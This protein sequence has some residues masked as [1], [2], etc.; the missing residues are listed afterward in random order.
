MLK[1]VVVVALLAVAGYFYAGP[2]AVSQLSAT[3]LGALNGG[4]GVGR[5]LANG[6]KIFTKDELKQ[7][8]GNDKTKGTYVAVA[9]NVFDVSEGK[10]YQPGGGYAFF[11]GV[12]GSRAYVTGDFK[13]D[14]TDD[15]DGLSI[16]DFRGIKGWLKFYQDHAKYK[17]VGKVIGLFYNENG[18]L[19]DDR[20]V[21]VPEK[22]PHDIYP[23]C[24][25]KYNHQIDGREIWCT[26]K[27]GGIDRTWIGVPRQISMAEKDRDGKSQEKCVCVPEGTPTAY[28]ITEY[29]GCK[30]D[31]AYCIL[32]D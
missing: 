17:Y 23:G 10:F 31:K 29:D 2:E 26:E 12:D 19:L 30:P 3:V 32:Y 27:S 5:T 13:G 4:G 24:N 15:I 18:E 25:S 1:Q 28:P 9:G 8:D 20:V 14:L 6:D 11:S 22:D 21:N 16:G 7:F